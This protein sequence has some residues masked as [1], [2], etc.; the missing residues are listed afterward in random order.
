MKI[1]REI[2]ETKKLIQE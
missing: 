2:Q 1:F